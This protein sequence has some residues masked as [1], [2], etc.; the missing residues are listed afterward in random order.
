MGP[1]VSVSVRVS[2]M[3]VS[4][5][6]YRPRCSTPLA[7]GRLVHMTVIALAVMAMA[8]IMSMRAHVRRHIGDVAV[9][10]AALG[11]DVIGERLHLVAPAL[12]HGDF[13]TAVMV[14]MNV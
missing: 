1:M 6:G 2:A 12:E 13:E 14:E 3:A 9:A 5:P 10:H 11:D 4:C 8:V 7:G